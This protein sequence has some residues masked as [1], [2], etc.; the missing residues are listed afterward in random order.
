MYTCIYACMDPCVH[1]GSMDAWI[2][3]FMDTCMDAWAIESIHGWIHGCICGFM[4]PMD[5]WISWIQQTNKL[6]RS[7]TL[8]RVLKEN[9]DC[10][11]VFCSQRSLLCAI[12]DF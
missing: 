5:S 11:S 2:H 3:V 4:D 10:S 7:G 9:G 12:Y 1:Q 6:G 8:V